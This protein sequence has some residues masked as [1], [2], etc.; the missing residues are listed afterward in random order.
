MKTSC[1]SWSYHRTIRAKQMDQ[2][3][4]IQECADIGLDGVELL[5]F[6]FPSTAPEYLVQLK[7]A[8]TNHYLTIAMV[9]AGGHLTVTDDAKRAAE[10]EDIRKWVDVAAFMGAPCVRFFCGSGAELEAGGP[11]LFKKV[12]AA[13]RQV[14]E[15]GAS[16]GI[17]MALENHGGT[18]ADQLL[19]LLKEVDHPFLKFTLD[20]GNFPPTSKVGPETYRHIERCAPHAAIVHA[21]FFNVLADGRDQD[22]DWARIHGILQKTGFRGFLSIEYEG[23]NADE[24]G[25]IRRLAGYLKT[26]R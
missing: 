1:S 2:L 8:C 19:A 12:K 7:K 5:G 15:I 10:V 3:S 18:T 25:C 22:F 17:V 9:S 13:M 23:E 24:V 20:T 4:W 6:H 21:K 14:A 16:R 26:L 11:E